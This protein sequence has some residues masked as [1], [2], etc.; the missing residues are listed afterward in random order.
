MPTTC[1]SRGRQGVRRSGAAGPAG[2]HLPKVMVGLVTALI[3][4]V[5]VLVMTKQG[6]EIDAATQRFML[7]YAGVFALI[8][9]R[10]SVV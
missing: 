9:D 10:K 2:E 3:V 4:V 7:F 8:G 5:L 6:R 1:R